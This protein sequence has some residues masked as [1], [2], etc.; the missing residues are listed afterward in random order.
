[1]ALALLPAAATAE[2]GFL[3]GLAPADIWVIGEVH[4]NPDHHANQA[5]AVAALMPSALV[6]E[7]LTPEQATRGQPPRPAEAEALA[8]LLDWAS[9]GWP[10]F[11]L[12]FPI[13][14]AAPGASVH[15]GALPRDE[16][17]RAI[18]EG[19]AEVFGAGA[20]DFGLAE[21]LDPDQQAVREAEMAVSHCDALPASLLPG[22]V[23]AQRLRDAAL[24]RAA[25][26]AHA[27]TGGPV[28]VI[29]GTGHARQDWGIPAAIAHAAPTL[30]VRAIGQF[31]GHAGPENPDTGDAFDRVI[32]AEAP[33]R[34]DPC[35]AF[36]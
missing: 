12:Y 18:T 29:A 24:A 27:A 16:V 10:D 5:R 6:F 25:I 23:E 32:R 21:P 19:A 28:V 35:A 2:V 20:A 3:D 34:P 33:P 13:F 17:R 36:R 11:D 15:G 31:E 26:E 14:A 4:G 7:M 8:E 9:G 1:M 30:T 22:M